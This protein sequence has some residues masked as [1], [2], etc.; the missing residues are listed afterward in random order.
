MPYKVAIIGLGGISGTH[1]AQ[2]QK[3]ADEA[4]IV[5]GADV[6]AEAV[7]NAE[8]A[9]GFKGYTDWR[10]MLEAER[11]DIVSICTPPFLHREMAVDCLQRGIH[12]LCEKPI[13]ATV[14]DA[15]AMAAAADAAEAKLMIAYCHRFHGPMMKLKEVLDSGI[16]GQ[17]IF[18]RGAFT[19]MVRF[20]TNHRASKQ[21]A[22]GGALMDNGSHA[23]DL[24]QYLLGKMT[25]VSCRAGTFIGQMETED[26]GIILFTGENG[27][28][29]EIIAGYALPGDFTQWIVTGEKG[30]L[31]VADYWGGPIRFRP[32]EGEGAQDFACDNS[33][34]RFDRMF[35]HFLDCV[36]TGTEPS[37]NAHTALHIARVMDAAYR[38]A[39]EP[40]LPVKL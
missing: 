30:V 35:D 26:V 10:A 9:H 5:A 8:A 6:N 37:T 12:V 27:C 34:S 7:S 15:E 29:G 36:K 40:G 32:H 17:P 24:Y 25:R 13:A 20:D 11:P 38:E 22:G 14:E 31:E 21:M 28:F 23:A 18:F 4:A 33:A 1:I 2:W 3:L 19:G 16:I 39:Q